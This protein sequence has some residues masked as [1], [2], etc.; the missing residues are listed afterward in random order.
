MTVTEESIQEL[1]YE[2][3]ETLNDLRPPD[4]HIPQQPDTVLFGREGVL[5]SLSLVSLI[6][7]IEQRLAEMSA[8]PISLSSEKAMSAMN[9]PF[10]TVSSLVDYIEKNM[11]SLQE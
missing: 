10:R 7:D 2:A 9:S 6:V 5:D 8:H 3:L 11:K 4:Q 1:I